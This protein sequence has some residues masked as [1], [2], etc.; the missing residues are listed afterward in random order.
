MD[1]IDIL[2]DSPKAYDEANLENCSFQVI[3]I[4]TSYTTK[5][6]TQD[7]VCLTFFPFSNIGFPVDFSFLREYYSSICSMSSKY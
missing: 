1:R 5:M 4:G 2:S 3:G 6:E 7:L